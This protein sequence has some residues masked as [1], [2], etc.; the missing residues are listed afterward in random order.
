MACHQVEGDVDWEVQEEGEG[1]GEGEGEVQEVQEVQGVQGVQ[2]DSVQQSFDDVSPHPEH[3][4][5]LKVFQT[6][7]VL[8]TD[9]AVAP[10]LSD[11]ESDVPPAAY[12][13]G[14]P[15]ASAGSVA[16]TAA[17]AP[18]I[19]GTDGAVSF[20]PPPAATTVGV[21]DPEPDDLPQGFSV[22]ISYVSL[23]VLHDPAQNCVGGWLHNPLM[24]EQECG[25]GGLVGAEQVA[26]AEMQGKWLREQQDSWDKEP[27]EAGEEVGVESWGACGESIEPH[28]V[29]SDDVAN[30][31]IEQQGWEGDPEISSL[32]SHDY[33]M[34]L[35]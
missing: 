25:G 35:Y 26:V 14:V 11:A 6:H 3:S 33:A 8:G 27:W 17:A 13:T 24:E 21:G 30:Q 20:P 5:H 31:D 22:D 29:Q 10:I 12:A 18:A 1:E 7:S 4:V 28:G 19:A 15:S 16:A 32:V 9:A 23:D 2:R 34:C